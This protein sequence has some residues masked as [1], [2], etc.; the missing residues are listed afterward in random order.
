MRDE[1]A[2]RPTA[3]RQWRTITQADFLRLC[4]EAGGV[5]SSGQLL[6][7]LHNTGIV[8]YRHGLLLDRIIIDQ[9]WALESIYSIFHREKCVKKLQ[10]QKGRFTRSDLADWL[11][12]LAGHS[13]AEQELFLSMMQSCGICFAQRPA[14]PDKEI[15]TEYIAPDFLPE[16]SGI[17]DDLALKWDANLPTESTEFDFSFLHPGLMRTII[18]KIGSKAGL[19]ADYWH[20]GMFTYEAV[21]GSR[22]L[23]EE[24]QLEGW[25]GRIR[26][27]TQRGQAT[28]LLDRLTKLIEEEQRGMGITPVAVRTTRTGARVEVIRGASV[29]PLPLQFAQ[30]P[31]AKPEYFVSYAWRDETPEGKEREHIVDD[32]CI[33]AEERGITILR[34][35]KVLGLGDQI[36]KFMQRI[37]RGNRVFVVLSNKYLKSPFCMYELYELWRNC[38]QDDEEFLSHVRVYT[39]PD[40]EV[41]TPLERAQCAAYW[42]DESGKLEAVFKGYGF[43]IL[44]KTD[45]QKYLLMKDFSHQIGEILA[46]VTDVLQPRDFEELKSYGFSDGPGGGRSDEVRG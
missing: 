20:G 32:L 26:V 39:L 1:D 18:S 6:S 5:S 4:K 19:N 42:R 25:Q 43:D 38:R 14:Q 27:S 7:Y 46:T 16:K 33:A 15:G 2:S 45:V 31:A 35:K 30:E 28:V 40:A 10:R 34:D 23:I 41:W 12:D 37:G 11:W 24:E 3:E 13:L 29:S 8:F 36:S 22:A 17:A 9:S 21:S 44:G